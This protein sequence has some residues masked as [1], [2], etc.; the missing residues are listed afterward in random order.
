MLRD[1]LWTR[2]NREVELASEHDFVQWRLGRMGLH[3]VCQ[4]GG[5][6]PTQK[7]NAIKV[8]QKALA[9]IA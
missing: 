4:L 1:E 6:L 8:A 9:K 2:V 7:A 5:P 3:A